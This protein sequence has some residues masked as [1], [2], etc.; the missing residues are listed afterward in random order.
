MCKVMEKE[1]QH[2]KITITREENAY[3]QDMLQEFPRAKNVKKLK[4]IWKGRKADWI[5]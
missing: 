4:K 5:L 2:Y 3:W 1:R